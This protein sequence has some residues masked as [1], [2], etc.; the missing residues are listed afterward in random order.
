[1]KHSEGWRVRQRR[2]IRLPSRTARVRMARPRSD[3]SGWTRGST[4]RERS[5]GP[6]VVRAAP[7]DRGQRPR[8]PRLASR[9]GVVGP[10]LAVAPRLVLIDVGPAPIVDDRD[11]PAGAF[12]GGRAGSVPGQARPGRGTGCSVGRGSG[13]WPVSRPSGV[14]DPGGAGR[15]VTRALTACEGLL[16]NSPYRSWWTPLGRRTRSASS[17]SKKRV[18]PRRFESEDLPVRLTIGA[19]GFPA[20]HPQ[21]HVMDATFFLPDFASPS[22]WMFASG[23]VATIATTLAFS[24]SRP[25]SIPGLALRK[26]PRFRPE[27]PPFGHP[28]CRLEPNAGLSG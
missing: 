19:I 26:N 16:V 11:G 2:V 1:M 14:A 15:T 6:F 24:T 25:P 28:A 12:G 21:S 22:W 5:P 4:A 20:T 3:P 13:S 9:V 10:D 7:G 8:G 17:V 23:V 27:F 18:V